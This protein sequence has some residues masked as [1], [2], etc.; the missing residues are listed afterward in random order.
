MKFC[1]MFSIS[2]ILCYKWLKSGRSRK[3]IEFRLVDVSLGV[4]Y[5]HRPAKLREFAGF[6]CGQKR[7]IVCNLI[8][9]NKDHTCM[10]LGNNDNKMMQSPFIFS[11]DPLNMHDLYV[12]PANLRQ[13]QTEIEELKHKLSMNKSFL[14]KKC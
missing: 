7:S 5:I 9:N 6:R 13:M 1:K 2:Y 10:I 8:C 14:K 4:Q 12:S 3:K 11:E